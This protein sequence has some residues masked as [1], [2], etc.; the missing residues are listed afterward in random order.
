MYSWLGRY[1][2]FSSVTS[3]ICTHCW[4]LQVEDSILAPSAVTSTTLI[5][6][7]SCSMVTV[8][9]RER[10]IL[11]YSFVPTIIMTISSDAFVPCVSMDTPNRINAAARIAPGINQF[12]LLIVLPYSIGFCHLRRKANKPSHKDSLFIITA[13]NECVNTNPKLLSA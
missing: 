6:P 10:G 5:Y 4:F 11:A 7:F 13:E 9:G 12:L 2:Q 8:C 1:S 3:P